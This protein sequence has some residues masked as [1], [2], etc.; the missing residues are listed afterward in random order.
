MPWVVWVTTEN[1]LHISNQQAFVGRRKKKDSIGGFVEG[2]NGRV[3][4]FIR[5]DRFH[6]T[7]CTQGAFVSSRL[8]RVQEGGNLYVSQDDTTKTVSN[9]KQG[10][11]PKLPI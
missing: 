2:C 3:I 7:L 10:P 8:A 11:L 5:L 1:P 9:E 6:E 4:I